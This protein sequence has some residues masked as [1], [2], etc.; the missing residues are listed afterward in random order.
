MTKIINFNVNLLREIYC[1]MKYGREFW[2]GKEYNN[3]TKTL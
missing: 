1:F 2:K 3:K